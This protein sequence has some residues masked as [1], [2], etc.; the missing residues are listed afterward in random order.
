MMKATM[1]RN[2]SK[3]NRIST[4]NVKIAKQIAKIFATVI[5]QEKKVETRREVLC[6]MTDFE[7]YSK[8]LSILKYDKANASGIVNAQ[9]FK[10]F[11]EYN[12]L[13]QGSRDYLLLEQ[14]RELL[15]EMQFKTK[16]P[17]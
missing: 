10:R 14:D 4:D 6:E 9:C 8:Y 17:N 12:N 2:T 13:S 7:P 1:N 5:D 16:N 11:L 3:T 15:F